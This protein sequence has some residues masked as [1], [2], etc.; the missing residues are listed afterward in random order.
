[1]K[2]HTYL[3]A[4]LFIFL[5]S[6]S[7]AQKHPQG[8]FQF[9]IKSGQQASLSGTFG[10][11]RSNHFHSGIDIKTGGRQ[12]LNVY[13]SADGYVSRIKISVYGYGKA[14]YI[15]HP[16]GYTTVYAHLQHYNPRIDSIIRAVQ[17]SSKSFS[18]NYFPKRGAIKIKK[19][20]VIG[21]SGNTGGSMGPHLHFEIRNSKQEPLNP[22]LF[23][24]KEV[25]DNIPPV[26]KNLAI[27]PLSIQSRINGEFD[28]KVFA[29]KNSG[30]GVY[31]LVGKDTI[32]TQGAFHLNLETIDKLNG[33][34]NRNGIYELK[35]AVDGT[36][37]YDLNIDHFSFAHTR[38]IN[39]HVNF[40]LN[41][42]IGRRFYKIYHNEKN[43]LDFYDTFTNKGILHFN[44]NRPHK[45]KI[46]CTDTYGNTSRLVFWVKNKRPKITYPKKPNK[47]VTY[48]I[49]DNTMRVTVPL[50]TEA[51]ITTHLI[52]DE[53]AI[54]PAYHKGKGTVYLI[55]L[56]QGVPQS[57]SQG[58]ELLN[59]SYLQQI[60][61]NKN[62]VLNYNEFKI[63]IPKNVI[64]S[65]MYLM[66]KSDGD[67]IT[68]GDAHLPIYKNY[69]VTNK[70]L[71]KAQNP[72]LGAYHIDYRG[73]LGYENNWWTTEG[74][75]FRT[76]NLGKFKY[77]NDSIP[78]TI[79]P[80]WVNNHNLA[81]IIKDERSGIKGYTVK[82]NGKWIL[83]NYDY[84]SGKIWSE[85]KNKN[86]VLKGDLSVKVTDNQGNITTFAKKLL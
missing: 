63:S 53:K 6:H 80:L 86:Q 2:K 46:T 21:A 61:I 3:F 18:V 56:T 41:K 83:M 77:L 79:K 22:L 19:G 37:F 76:R 16:N 42:T 1:M 72:Y 36:V 58:S 78:P 14:I 17:Y 32:F 20:E 67:N 55:D 8:Y 59:F 26:I 4:L 60:K 52:N 25:K 23:G 51:P 43:R 24:F 82:V 45:I 35:I 9:P 11:L 34:N 81:F 71:K 27:S 30:H 13:A 73:R 29:I 28:E 15:D 68:L 54:S 7:F 39:E 65:T 66:A 10:E 74:L 47:E 33:A 5:G 70:A 62:Y 12:G 75:A 38:M 64:Y 57:I 44:D 48:T 31:S 85:L 49:I 84:K 40:R 50:L 69:T